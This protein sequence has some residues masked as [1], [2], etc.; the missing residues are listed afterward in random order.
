[1]ERIAN[2]SVTLARALDQGWTIERLEREYILTALDHVGWRKAE[3]AKRLGIDRRTLYRKL[4]RYAPQKGANQGHPDRPS[5]SGG[6]P[7]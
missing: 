4:K 6:E 2:A 7:E 1:M 3:A 5:D